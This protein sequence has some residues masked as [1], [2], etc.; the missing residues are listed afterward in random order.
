[1]KITCPNCTTRYNVDESRFLPDGRSVRCSECDES[2]FV[3]AP[4][5]IDDLL[6]PESAQ[7]PS[8]KGRGHHNPVH[9]R[10]RGVR[11]GRDPQRR[12][13]GR[14]RGAYDYDGDDDYDGFDDR[15]EVIEPARA[16]GGDGSRRTNGPARGDSSEGYRDG[17]DDGSDESDALFADRSPAREAHGRFF[18]DAD[19][20]DDDDFDADE[21]ASRKRPAN[22]RDEQSAARYS[23]KSR[24]E[25]GRDSGS[26]EP[27]DVE[28]DLFARPGGFNAD[29]DFDDD[30]DDRARGR[31]RDD[32]HHDEQDDERNDRGLRASRH[33]A[34]RD[35]EWR[36]DRKARLARERMEAERSDAKGADKSQ[37]EKSGSEKSGSEDS[38][39]GKFGAGLETPPDAHVVDVDFEDIDSDDQHDAARRGHRDH[40]MRAGA[41][42]YDEDD[43]P[44][45]RRRGSRPHDDIMLDDDAIDP[46]DVDPPLAEESGFGRRAWGKHRRSTALTPIDDLAPL[47]ERVFDEE[48]L[49]AMHVQPKELERAIR[50]ARRR[51][52][53]RYK[54][55]LTPLA[56]V[57]WIT[58]AGLIGVVGFAGYRFRNDI[59]AYY[60]KAAEAYQAVGIDAN[61]YGLRIEN[62]AHRVAMST[63]GP[64]IE[65]RGRLSN[66]SSSAVVP[67]LLQAEALGPRG[68]LLSRWTFSANGAEV[69]EGASVDFTTR[70]PAPDGVTEIALSFTPHEGVRQSVEK[71]IA[72]GAN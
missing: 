18:R 44:R 36:P 26:G 3:P 37:S 40:T 55:R 53:A 65:I 20:I 13:R 46:D 2:W 17:R 12:S 49:T 22:R 5:D 52:E 35:A 57:G 33:G 69:P 30:T 14:A 23:K 24:K 31:E 42:D 8:Q 56:A 27:A 32:A 50:K 48:F 66:Q 25:R 45:A 67:P 4:D 6:L 16:R 21:L 34:A 63:A 60:P 11:V 71:L 54:N 15:A 41:D 72:N 43:H 10:E 39:S 47:A 29:I 19:D 58:L 7:A 59:V 38:D 68:E 51:A 9:W 70:A 64:T 1:M 28:D 62:V 61:P